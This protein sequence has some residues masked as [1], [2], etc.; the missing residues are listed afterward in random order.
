MKTQGNVPTGSA[1]IETPA[2]NASVRN[3]QIIVAGTSPISTALVV[4]M[5][6]GSIKVAEEGIGTVNKNWSVTLRGPFAPGVYRID[7]DQAGTTTVNVNLRVTPV[8]IT[9]PANGTQ[10]PI[11][12]FNVSGSGGEYGVGTVSL[13]DASNNASLGNA[14]IQTNGNW[15]KTLT[16]TGNNLGFYARQ[17]IGGYHSANSAT[18]NVSYKVATVTITSP[19]NGAVVTSF[20]PTVSGDGETGASISVHRAENP[21]D[22]Y[23]SGSVV[24]GK[25]NI[26]LTKSLP[27]GPITLQATQ[28]HNGQTT[29]SNQVPITVAVKLQTPVISSPAAGSLQNSAF[30]VGGTGGVVGSIMRIVYDLDHSKQVGQASVTADNWTVPVTVDPGRRSLVAGQTGTG[31]NPSDFSQ[32]RAFD[33][34]PPVLTKVNVTVPSPTTVTFDGDGHEG[35]TVA[36][37]V[38]SG[39]GGAAP[40]EAKVVG[41]KWETSATNW[42]DGLYKMSAIQKVSDN[43]GGWIESVPYPFEFL[44]KFP[45]PSDVVSTPEYSTTLSGNGVSGATVSLYDSDGTTKIAPDA[46]VGS[47]GQW[48]SKA[49]VEWGPTYDRVVRIRQ[50]LNAQQSDFVEH[51]VRIPPIAPG[52]DRVPPE[53]LSPTFTG[54]CELNAQVNLVFSGS[55]S[56]YPATV[57]GR[58]WTCQRAEPFAPE[59]DHTVTATQIAAQQTS[60]AATE[61]FRLFTPM[62]APLITEPVK[63]SEVGRDVIF[64]GTDGMSGATVYLWDYVSGEPLGS[65]KLTA[66]GAWQIPVEKLKFGRWVVRAKQEIDGRESA[67]SESHPFDVVLLAPDFTSP[68]EGG[69]LARTSMIEGQGEALG[70]VDVFLEGAAEPLL[71]HLPIGLDGKWKG[72]VTLPVGHKIIWARQYF[73]DQTSQDSVP[74][75]YS[76]VPAPPVLETPVPGAHV[77]QGSV[78]SGFGV[79][80]DRIIVWMIRVGAVR[81]GET[82]VQADGTWSVAMNVTQPSRVIHLM[83]TATWDDFQS[84]GSAARAVNLGTYRPVFEKPAEGQSVSDPVRFAGLGRAGVVHVRS[85]F[86]PEREWAQATAFVGGWQ[87]DATGPLPSGGQWCW[88]QQTITDDAGGATISDHVLSSR[89]EVHPTS[90]G[91]NPSDLPDKRRAWLSFLTV[92]MSRRL[93]PNR[94]NRTDDPT[95][96]AGRR[97]G[98]CRKEIHHGQDPQTSRRANV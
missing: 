55:G 83:V 45:P 73:E 79:L 13:F 16:I 7:A 68:Q 56:S 44:F 28:T 47:N 66:D 77:G 51:K 88:I 89:F 76:V 32:P 40:G 11:R 48:S 19:V 25:W 62:I 65:K 31:I 60:R 4:R 82:T 33:I 34:R 15:T 29:S 5:Y 52:I 14:D 57:T 46:Q 95:T 39:P 9:S 64:Q 78:A 94:I 58:T 98:F 2:N 17:T 41:G 53:G 67:D 12:Q 6:S 3:S 91:K 38:V 86:N 97:D 74:V 72:E 59:I 96:S 18:V 22:V 37:T 10:F 36:I 69:R 50:F 75:N 81:A 63:D 35:A 1:V 21:A 54:T 71:E 92:V 87:S 42:P 27:L 24:S 93:A 43:A 80:G 49:Y 84:D 26:P 23:G 8:V 85:W 30:T 61:T 20:N 70:T 90:P